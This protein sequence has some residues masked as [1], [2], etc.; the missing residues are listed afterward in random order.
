MAGAVDC[1]GA[2]P[3]HPHQNEASQSTPD[4]APPSPPEEP[5]A[6]P[7]SQTPRGMNDDTCCGTLGA[8]QEDSSVDEDSGCCSPTGPQPR[9]LNK[10]VAADDCCAADCLENKEPEAHG[11]CGAK[12]IIQVSSDGC[13]GPRGGVENS[14]AQRSDCC[15]LGVG[16]C[17]SEL[18]P[19][20]D[21][22][23]EVATDGRPECCQGK[24]APC[25]DEAC[26]DRIALRECQNSR[27]GK[28]RLTHPDSTPSL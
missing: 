2:S 23:S 18:A 14:P 5:T 10:D 7:E 15:A 25:C 20:G 11:C 6:T 21:K 22:L 8:C 12:D 26:L 17:S 24:A 19:K 27:P 3:A 16:P 13:S 28:G 1:C 4:L 9:Q